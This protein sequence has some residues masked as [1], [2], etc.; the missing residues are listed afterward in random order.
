MLLHEVNSKNWKDVFSQK[1]SSFAKKSPIIISMM[2]KVQDGEEGALITHVNSGKKYFFPFDYD[3]KVGDFIFKIKTLL[4][5]KHYP[6]IIEEILE[7]HEFTKEELATQLENSN[8]TIDT[9]TK[10][11]MRIIGRRQ[12]RIDKVLL[13]KNIFLLVLESSSFLDDEIGKI[14]RYKL[15]ISPVIFLRNY[16][17][18]KFKSLEEA[19][20]FFFS[21][22]IL[23]DTIN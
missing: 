16:R 10:Y 4:S 7:K 22:S 9:L 21:N 15:N 1:F 13:W 11:E 23:I 20:N 6:R 18:N 2:I 17:S 8:Q 5:E 3:L 19:S 14:Y 12:F